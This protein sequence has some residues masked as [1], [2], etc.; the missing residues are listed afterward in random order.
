MGIY[1]TWGDQIYNSQINILEIAIENNNK[2]INTICNES[3][4]TESFS[5]TIKSFI[6]RVKEVID[7]F[8]EFL[9]SIPGKIKSMFAKLYSKENQKKAEEKEED[10]KQ[11]EEESKQPDSDVTFE[12]KSYEEKVYNYDEMVGVMLNRSHFI[13][14][15][16]RSSIIDYL[17][18]ETALKS[19][20]DGIE[21]DF[22][23]SVLVNGGGGKLHGIKTY[24][25]FKEFIDTDEYKD[26]FLSKDKSASQ[27]LKNIDT[28]KKMY[29]S[30]HDIEDYS[31]K[32]LDH[33]TKVRNVV[34]DEMWSQTKSFTGQNRGNGEGSYEIHG[35]VFEHSR[36][37]HGNLAAF[38]KIINISISTY[39]TIIHYSI[40]TYF[41]T[42]VQLNKILAF[43]DSCYTKK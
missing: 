36:D 7:K 12:D 43:I 14:G 41:D 21:N 10:I 42:N 26:Q 4:V 1:G 23:H 29:N 24:S 40:R 30:I 19:D 13:L 37:Y 2:F 38:M 35:K 3:Y 33:W 28:Y 31:N 11:K 9:K 16:D 32:L 8:I 39:K 27:L 22:G 20:L 15:S 17:N 18:N 5:D 6:N 34:M 25:E